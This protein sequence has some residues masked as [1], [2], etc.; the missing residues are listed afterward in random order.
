MKRENEKTIVEVRAGSPFPWK[1]IDFGMGHM[2]LVDANGAVVPLLRTLALVTTITAHM[3][4]QQ[5]Q[6]EGTETQEAA[7]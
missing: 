6:K 2:D 5:G 7:A 3:A 1:V 4:T